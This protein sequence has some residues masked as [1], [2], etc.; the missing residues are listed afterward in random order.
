MGDGSDGFHTNYFVVGLL[1]G[2]GVGMTETYCLAWNIRSHLTALSLILV[3][4]VLD[5]FSIISLLYFVVF[6]LLVPLFFT[7]SG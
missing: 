5:L 6:Y 1:V 3:F 4:T 7:Y 2:G